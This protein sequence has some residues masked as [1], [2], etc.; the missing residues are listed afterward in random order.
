MMSYITSP[1]A[2][3]SYVK[4]PGEATRNKL[5][6]GAIYSTSY[7]PSSLSLIEISAGIVGP[8]TVI[9]NFCPPFFNC[10]PALFLVIILNGA[11]VFVSASGPWGSFGYLD[12][13]SLF[14]DMAVAAPNANFQ[15]SISGF[16]T[17]GNQDAEFELINGLLHSRY[18]FQGDE[19]YDDE[20]YEYDDEKEIEWVFE[21]IFNPITKESKEIDLLEPF[22]IIVS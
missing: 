4:Y 3:L 16:N 19:Y 18:A 13:I 12:E 17:G 20:E 21:V 11:G 6:D 10:S 22:I 8:S 5:N 2:L 15:G 1:V 7:V 14:E 9:L